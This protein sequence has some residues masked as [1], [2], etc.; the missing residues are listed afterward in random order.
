MKKMMKYYN[1]PQMETICLEAD[2]IRTSGLTSGGEGK[3]EDK[4]TY[5]YKELFGKD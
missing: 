4:N 2:I 1:A 5:D 3:V